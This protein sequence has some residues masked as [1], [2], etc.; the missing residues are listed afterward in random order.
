VDVRG[1]DRGERKMLQGMQAF[2]APQLSSGVG[3][4]AVIARPD[5]RWERVFATAVDRGGTRAS[6]V[7]RVVT[8]G[9]LS[10]RVSGSHVDVNSPLI[11]HERDAEFLVSLYEQEG[12]RRRAVRA[13]L[14]P[15]ARGKSARET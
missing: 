1:H 12:L 15:C 6:I 7:A 10:S 8:R 11:A 5:T 3:P 4:A 2:S 14:S 13:D 9:E